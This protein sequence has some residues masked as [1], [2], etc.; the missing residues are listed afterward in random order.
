MSPPRAP[1][2]PVR[3]GTQA[4]LRSS[5]LPSSPEPCGLSPRAPFLCVPSDTAED[6][7]CGSQVRGEEG[8]E[9]CHKPV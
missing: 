8:L 3:A 2:F 9:G 6:F 7:L 5:C 1:H 4:G